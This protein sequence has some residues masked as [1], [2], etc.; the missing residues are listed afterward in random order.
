[1]SYLMIDCAEQLQGQVPNGNLPAGNTFAD[2]EVPVGALDGVNKIFT[3]AHAPNPSASLMLHE[4]GLLM[5][6]PVDFSLV[7]SA[8]TFVIAPPLQSILV[9]SYRY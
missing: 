4:N 5:A 7:G 2:A 9:A 8:I 6:S 3:L 1:M